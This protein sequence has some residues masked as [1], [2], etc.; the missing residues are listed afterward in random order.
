MTTTPI[1]NTSITTDFNVDELTEGTLTGKGVFDVLLQTLR[2]HL[3]RE[4]NNNRITGTAYATVYSQAITAF[5]AQAAQYA[6]SKAKLPL[7]LQLLQEQINLTQKQQDQITSA[8]RQTDY[9][10]DYQLPSDTAN[11][12]K[13]TEILAY[14]LTNIKP[15]E[16]SIAQ[17]DL[18]LKTAQADLVEYDLTTLKPQELALLQQQVATQLYT[19]Q[20]RMPAEVAN[21]QAE[22][23]LKA[24]DL[25]DIKPTEKGNLI[26]TGL[27]ITAQT[28]NTEQSTLNLVKQGHLTDSQK[29]V[30]DKQALNTEAQTSLLAYDLTDIKPVEK[31]NLISTRLRT[32]AETSLLVYDLTDIKPTEKAQITQQTSNLS[33]Q[34]EQIVAETSRV[35]YEVNYRLPE[36]VTLIKRN[37]DQVVAQTDK[38]ATDTVVTIK[39]GHLT[40]AQTCQVKAETNQVNAVVATKL[41]KEVAQIEAQTSL[42]AYDL[43]NIKPEEKNNLIN[44]GLNTEAQTALLAYDLTDIK[45]VEKD[46]LVSTGLSI[47]AQTSNTEQTTANLVKQGLLITAET[48]Q[49][50]YKTDIMM[51]EELKVLQLNQDRL[52]AE[53]T[54]ASVDTIVSSKQGNLVDAQACEVKASANKINAEVALKLPEEI[55]IL[56]RNQLQLT[57]QTG[58]I[59]YRVS[60]LLP[61]Q[62]AQNTAQTAQITYTTSYVLPSQVSLTNAQTSSATA[63]TALYNQKTVT[64]L[65][66][67]T[68][69]P[70]SGSVMGVQNDLMATQKAS[71]LR[72]A[73]QKAAKMLIDTWNVRRNAEPTSNPVT[74]DNR[75]RDED[76]GDAVGKML[77]GIGVV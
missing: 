26:S 31:N 51:P 74:S 39:Q 27:N 52:R 43:T 1:D 19:V 18:A 20:T 47:N 13:Q 69:T 4:F 62:T 49:V 22:T 71:Y 16:L 46:N 10:T 57:A 76:I 53:I 68:T 50:T 41:P 9:V 3:D 54:K 8:I 66:Q 5:L 25:T 55:E 42:L 67:T 30:A 34:Q 21:I 73:E 44:T 77:T 48:S 72:D 2:L 58:E 37:Q 6:I 7:E 40:D 17:Q 56:K 36:E 63:Q 11:K 64:E 35:L 61:S 24:Y 14:E 28:S 15:V 70:A 29:V 33:S 12:T 59:D 65:A 32:E 60:T 45:P 38:V 23:A 75:L